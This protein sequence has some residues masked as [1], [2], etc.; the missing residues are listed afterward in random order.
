MGDVLSWMITG[1]L[2]SSN[3]PA[4]AFA[5]DTTND[6]R[7]VD[8]FI[9][10]K[11]NIRI[12]RTTLWYILTPCL[13]VTTGLSILTETGRVDLTMK[14]ISNRFDA[15]PAQINTTSADLIFNTDETGR[16][17]WYHAKDLLVPSG[18]ELDS[19]PTHVPTCG[20]HVTLAA[21]I[22][23]DGSHTRL[24]WKTVGNDMFLEPVPRTNS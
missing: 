19:I 18:S 6:F 2:L 24:S 11:F 3:T 22:V 7:N 9:V 17:K 1:W 21:K 5:P 12:K 15:A 13:P 20:K 14:A 23:T 4:G 10:P 16:Q 8:S